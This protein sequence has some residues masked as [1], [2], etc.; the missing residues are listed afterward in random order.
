MGGIVCLLVS[1]CSSEEGSRAKVLRVASAGEALTLDP[2]AISDTESVQV[3]MQIFEQLVRYKEG[4]SQIE[5]ALATHWSVDRRGI[6]W[7]FYLRRGVRFHDGSPMNADS[8]V[9]SLER[10]RDRQ[11]P[12]HFQ[13]FT[14]W[15]STFRNIQKI[16]KVDEYTVQIRIE[17]PFAPFLANLAMFPAS[18]VSPTAMK[19]EGR[20]F[21][22]RPVG[23]G[24][25]QIVQWIKGNKIILARNPRHWEKT[26]LITHLIYEVVPDANQRLVELQSGT[27]DVMYDLAPS[28]RQL[29][30]LHPDLNLY[31][32]QGNNVA[33]LAMN[34]QKP[35]FDDPR[36]RQA[37][38][39]AINKEAIV[40]L[41]Y[42]GLA[43]SANGPIPPNLW[44]HNKHIRRYAYN[45]EL[46]KKILA[47]TN[48]SSLY[49]PKLYVMS[50]PRPYLP[51]PILAARMIA[52]NLAEV[53]MKVDLVIRP[54]SEHLRATQMGEHDL[55]L[56]GW[57]GDNGD[58]DNFL[59]LL[60][61]Q[62]NARRGAA[63]NQAMFTD[64]KFHQLLLRG[65]TEFNPKVRRNYYYLAQEIIAEQAPWV[66]LAHTDVV[67]A[68]QKSV[69]NL[70][71]HP[72]T[73][74]FYRKV[75]KN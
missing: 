24:P 70:H 31:I 19:K 72:S 48:Y 11:H 65:Q 14:Y 35:P 44:G 56:S 10:Q 71:V 6:L 32:V 26:P 75:S 43:T 62:E 2:A 41:V 50:T 52:R 17:R 12:F 38:N 22:V 45:P 55:C 49:H 16:K 36:V 30:R 54:W 4:S 13:D 27:I 40:K 57:A 34:T 9:F 53:G 51:S 18:I 46:A 64:E 61:D 59:F 66:P 5:P 74:I 21:A 67:V 60:L 15:E 42:Q 33:F 29:V 47:K 1:R 8:V 68:A 37:V 28:D 39:Y 73:V 63:R 3:A 23:T 20:Q 69:H 58:P 25:Y 7:T